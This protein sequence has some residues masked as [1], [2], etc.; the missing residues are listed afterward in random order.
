MKTEVVCALLSQ[1]KNDAR[2]VDA[3]LIFQ[4]YF[5]DNG[6][7]FFFFTK[8]KE[9]GK[10]LVKHKRFFFSRVLLTLCQRRFPPYLLPDWEW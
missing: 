2:I 1:H 5:N 10:R 9:A 3:Q 7:G 6:L 4:T 8:Y